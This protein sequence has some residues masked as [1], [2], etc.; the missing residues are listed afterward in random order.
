LSILSNCIWYNIII[1]L[2]FQVEQG[3]YL[4]KKKK[5]KIGIIG[6]GAAGMMA[7]VSAAKILPGKEIAIFEKNQV[8]G[9]KVL[10]TGNGK[11]N[12]SNQNCS[13]SDYRK[14]NQKLVQEVFNTMS[15]QNTIVLFEEMGI[16]SRTDSEGRIYPYSEQSSS[17]KEALEAEIQFANVIN[18][19]NNTVMNVEK[20]VTG[21]EITLSNEEVWQAERLIIATGGKAGSQFGSTGDGYGFAK[22]F[23]HTLVRPM[24][25]LVQMLSSD[26]SFHLY[27]GVRAKGSVTL[28]K[29]KKSIAME[30]GEIQFTENGLSG[31]CI[32]NLSRYLEPDCKDTF[33]KVDLFP[34]YSLSSLIEILCRRKNFMGDRTVETFLYGILNKKLIPSYLKQWGMDWKLPISAISF[35]E[36]KSLTKI[37]KSWMVPINGTKGWSEAQVTSGGINVSEINESTLESKQIPGLFFAGEVLDVDGKCGGWNLQW[38]WSSGYVAGRSASLSVNLRN[39]QGQE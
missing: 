16:L 10:A 6:G 34:E 30:M 15:P 12:F 4:M 39:K 31:I 32:F 28:Y 22:K 2:G 38:A 29:G 13:W 20:N 9:R 11:C 24:P 8:L 37:L 1:Y 33:V 27:K 36:V 5:V 14:Q 18:V 17:V 3:E 7:A 35:E 26:K 25:A 23:G 19:V 21:F